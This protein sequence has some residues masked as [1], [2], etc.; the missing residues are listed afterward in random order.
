MYD[1][2]DQKDVKKTR[3]MTNNDMS[4]DDDDDDGDRHG[5]SYICCQ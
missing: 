1:E 4:Y 2:S 5:T 3:A